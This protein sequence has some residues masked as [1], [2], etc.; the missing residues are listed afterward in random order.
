MESSQGDA[1]KNLRF[2]SEE[3]IEE[4]T[5][6]FF[7]FELDSELYAVSVGEV[8]HVMKIPPVTIVPNAPESIAGI[9]HLRGRVIVV[10]DLLKRMQL[11][12]GKAVVPNYLFVVHYQK[13]YFAIL[14]DHTK[15]VVRIPSREV[16]PPDRIFAARISPNYVKGMFMYKERPT[17]L[18]KRAHDFMIRP[19]NAPDG[20]APEASEQVRPVLWL[21]IE[22]LLNQ[23]DLMNI[24]PSS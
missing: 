2:F 9:F 23:H 4:P 16:G 8:D 5:L 17:R 7:L 14:A 21:N 19:I 6:E 13:N 11:E 24:T 20:T 3:V 1:Q 18:N 22:A 10:L 12:R 15:T